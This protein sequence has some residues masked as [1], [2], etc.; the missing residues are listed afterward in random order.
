MVLVIL[1]LRTQDGGNIA[2]LPDVFEVGQRAI[3]AI[4]QHEVARVINQRMDSR[5]HGRRSCF[6]KDKFRFSGHGGEM[7]GALLEANLFTFEEEDGYAG[8][9]EKGGGQHDKLVA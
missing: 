6:G 9:K 7:Q 1:R 2:N 8:E 3:N 4:Q 5:E